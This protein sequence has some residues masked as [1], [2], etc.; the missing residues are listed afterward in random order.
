MSVAPANQAI[1]RQPRSQKPGLGFP[2]RRMVGLLYGA[3]DAVLN[4]A[5]GACKGK[6]GDE[7]SLLRSILDTLRQRNVLLG[8]SLYAAHFLL[9]AFARTKCWRGV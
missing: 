4:T 8:D 7:Q 1:Y 2:L 5:T 6:G 9:C 3:T